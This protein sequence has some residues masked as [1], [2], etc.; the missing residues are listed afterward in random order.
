MHLQSGK[1]IP[2]ADVTCPLSS[3]HWVPHFSRVFCARSGDSPSRSR[4]TLVDPPEKPVHSTRLSPYFHGARSLPRVKHVPA[5][6]PLLPQPSSAPAFPSEV[7][8]LLYPLRCCKRRV[9]Q[10]SIGNSN[11]SL[12]H[13][14]SDL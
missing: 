4:T 10:T 11:V 13:P 14:T 5:I 3:S 7:A 6:P 2:A 12:I 9:F 8:E 1:T